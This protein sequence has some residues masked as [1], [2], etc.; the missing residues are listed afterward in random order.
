M[1]DISFLFI[2]KLSLFFPVYDGIISSLFENYSFLFQ[3]VTI[4]GIIDFCLLTLYY[5][6]GL[7][8][9]STKAWRA[10]TTSIHF[11]RTGTWKSELNK[12]VGST[13]SEPVSWICR[14]LSSVIFTFCVLLGPNNLSR[15]LR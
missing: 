15:G 14:W 5:C 6:G 4:I 12:L 1:S 2:L 7:Q 3:F 13:S 10:Y 8:E 9:Q 11:S